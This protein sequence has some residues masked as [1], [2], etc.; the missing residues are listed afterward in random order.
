MWLFPKWF[1]LLAPLAGCVQEGARLLRAPSPAGEI[2]NTSCLGWAAFYILTLARLLRVPSP[3]GDQP[4][5]IAFHNTTLVITSLIGTW[6]WWWRKKCQRNRWTKSEQI[7]FSNQFSEKQVNKKWN[8]LFSIVGSQKL[9]IQFWKINSDDA[10][11]LP[12]SVNWCLRTTARPW[13]AWCPS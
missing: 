9:S 13:H 8:K 5:S 12:P 3:A 7:K 6:Q 11:S 10:Q 2:V 4:G 1:L